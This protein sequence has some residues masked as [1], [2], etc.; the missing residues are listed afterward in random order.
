MNPLVVL[1]RFWALVLLPPTLLGIWYFPA[2][3]SESTSVNVSKPWREALAVV[4]R[5]TLLWL[6]CLGLGGWAVWSEIR[7]YVLRLF[8]KPGPIGVDPHIF[9]ES[10]LIEGEKVLRVRFYLTVRNNAR[11]K[12]TLRNVGASLQI[13]GASTQLRLRRSS[14]LR[15]DLRHSEYLLFEI[16]STM[17]V[18]STKEDTFVGL[19]VPDG[20]PLDEREKAEVERNLPNRN[21]KLRVGRDGSYYIG[22]PR[23]AE[24]IDFPYWIIVSADDVSSTIVR[25]DMNLQR[26][27]DRD[28]S[29]KLTV[30]AKSVESRAPQWLSN[31]G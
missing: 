4:D 31:I 3:L 10:E 9:C 15:Q 6:L 24:M 20:E 22:N 21:L 11:N 27:P 17:Y 2:D 30:N 14:E 18:G 26:L 13:V 8:R 23:N 12:A 29:F 7:P 5:E 1:K 25:V 28:A 19:F 16:G